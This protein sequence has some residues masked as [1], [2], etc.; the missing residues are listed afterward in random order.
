MDII[1]SMW[2]GPRLSTMESMCI[3][4]YL[5]HGHPFHL[6]VYQNT[7]NVPE[8]TT[9]LDANE[10]VPSSK[11]FTYAGRSFG[12]GSYAGFADLFRY[13]LL[14]TKGNWWVDTD[15][16][17]LRP[18]C[19]PGKE[20]VFSSEWSPPPY[21][22][23]PN[24][25]NLRAASAKSDVYGW[26]CEQTAT[27]NTMMAWGTIGPAL[28]K[29]AIERFRLE[30]YVAAPAVFCPVLYDEDAVNVIGPTARLVSM[31]GTLRSAHW[32]ASDSYAVH[33]WNEAWRMKGIDKDGAFD[34]HSV[35]ESLKRQYRRTVVPEAVDAPSV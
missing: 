19:F 28:I 9:V 4:S 21:G 29:Q 2:I 1:Q 13:K 10:I 31:A 25:G 7:E 26:L 14:H 8:G 12:R 3:A 27:I 15:S 20:Y 32:Q 17:C 11:I 18:F 30:R 35:Y 33:L 34:P 6:Y 5:R 22:F 24:C 16:F 23:H